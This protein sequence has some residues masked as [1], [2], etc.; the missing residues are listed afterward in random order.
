M[1]KNY[2]SW[3]LMAALSFG[4][5]FMAACSDDD[6]DN[7]GTNDSA[8][9]T[10]GET[11]SR[12]VIVADAGDAS[13]LATS[14]TLDEG[15]L[16][17]S[18]NGLETESGANWIFY[19]ESYLFNFQYNQGN[20]GT[21]FSYKL[22]SSGTMSEDRQYT[23]NRTTSYGTWGDYVITSST[24]AGDSEQDEDGNYAYYLYFNYLSV[25]DG[26][27]TTGSRIAENFLGNGE[28]VTFSGFVEANG[29]LY[30][31][32]VP[33]GMSVYGVNTYPE[34]VLDEGYI[35][36]AS[37][38]SN[39]ASYSAGSVPST[40]YPDCAFVAIYSG[41][42]F[43]E[44]PVIASTNQMGFASGRYRSQY[45]QTIWAADNGD[46]Y[47]FSPGYG[48]TTDPEVTDSNG[49]TFYRVQGK[50]PSSV[51]RIKAGETEFDSSYGVVNLEELGSGNPM[52]R[53]W[54]ITE[55]YFLLQMY[56][57]GADNMSGTTAPRNE[58]AVFKGEEGTLTVV[59]G[60]PDTNV[61]S[62]FGVPCSDNG[63]AYIPVVTTD[64]ASPTIY[65]IDPA[66]GFAT[67]GLTVTSADEISA[68]GKLSTTVE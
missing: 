18:G 58:L 49:N 6:S 10:P 34:C 32:V 21:G 3:A 52:F 39:S 12:F 4:C 35:A 11:I 14:E 25:L 24:S 60:L 20:A 28:Y 56:S 17:I 13:Y 37:G 61:L 40:Q 53:C 26:S 19:N 7:N 9:G 8:T 36:T 63:Y 2:F 65:R 33:M 47:A 48:R 15:T 46:V 30:T 23:Y 51:M 27:T 66:T 57:E 45:Y 44:T 38:G 29:Y 1:K 5:T 16:S 41:D 67:A 64:G 50:L 62:S 22:N 68:V 42:N 31:S 43:D 55:D 54:H 59:T